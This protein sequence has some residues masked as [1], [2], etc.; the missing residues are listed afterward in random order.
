MNRRGMK[1]VTDTNL[2]RLVGVRFKPLRKDNSRRVAGVLS[3]PR[4][5]HGYVSEVGPL[6]LPRSKVSP[7]QVANEPE[8]FN[9]FGG[10]GSA[11]RREFSCDFIEMC[12]HL[13]AQFLHPA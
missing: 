1:S 4:V 10:P 12:T 5:E 6:V 2:M 9:Y 3:V 8:R 11:L 7:N 13:L